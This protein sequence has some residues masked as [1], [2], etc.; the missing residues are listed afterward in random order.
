MRSFGAELS[1]FIAAKVRTYGV[2]RTDF[3]V[4]VQFLMATAI[5]SS[6]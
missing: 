5:V 1:A 4:Y 3:E 6:P 2:N